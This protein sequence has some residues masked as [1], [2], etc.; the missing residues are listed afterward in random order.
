MTEHKIKL[1]LLGEVS[2]GKTSVVEKYVKN[3]YV[4][5]HQPTIGAAYLSKTLDL[6]GQK[7]YLDIWDTAGQ[8]K[9]KAL[10]PLYYRGT[11]AAI[12]VYEITSKNTFEAAKSWVQNLE[13]NADEGIEVVLC[14]NK[15]DLESQRE[16]RR[17]EAEEYTKSK[18]LSYAECSAKTGKGVQELFQ[19][20]C[21]QLLER[22]K[23]MQGKGSD[24]P[25]LT[26]VDLQAAASA[27][28]SDGGCN[29]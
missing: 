26:A 17:E 11:A 16:V 1:V 12:V 23:G 3:E 21:R 8:E 28:P 2:V 9:Y 24:L 25:E 6:D 27:G 10:A 4:D 20:L 7:I 13:E 14:G 15:I 18:G 5:V 29:C 19:Q 22:R